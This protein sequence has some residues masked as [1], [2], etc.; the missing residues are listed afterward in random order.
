MKLK[1]VV[2]FGGTHGNE[3]TGIKIVTHYQEYFQKKF[4]SLKLEFILA[5]PEAYKLNRRFKDEDLN[6]AFQYL[7]ENRS[8]FEHTRAKELKEIILK[9]D[10]LVLDLHTTTSN[11][12]S[13]VIVSH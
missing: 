6:R 11:L 1:R 9:E 7:G 2:I 13:T 5:N 8:S 4:P 3:W 12:G 10:C